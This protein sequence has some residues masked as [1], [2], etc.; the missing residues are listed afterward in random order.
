ML[1]PQGLGGTLTFPAHTNPPKNWSPALSL[2]A[3][4]LPILLSGA[5]LVAMVA[6][7][8][9]I[10]CEE[11]LFPRRPS[12]AALIQ[13]ARRGTSTARA[14]SS[15]DVCRLGVWAAAEPPGPLGLWGKAILG[16]AFCALCMNLA[17][18]D[19]TP[20]LSAA[21]LPV[22]LGTDS[23]TYPVAVTTLVALVCLGQVLLERAGLRE[24]IDYRPLAFKPRV[25]LASWGRR[26]LAFA[27]LSAPAYLTGN[28]LFAVPPLLVAF[29]ELTRPDF[30]LRARPWRAW[31]VLA[32][33]GLVGSLGRAV[34]ETAGVP[35]PLMVAVCFAALVLVWNG[36]STWLPPA[37]AV[38]LLSF[39][40]PYAGPL[41]FGV[42]VAVG[43]AAWVAVAMLFPGVRP[44]HVGRRLGARSRQPS[45]AARGQRI[46]RL[47]ASPVLPPGEG[48]CYSPTDSFRAG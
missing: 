38:V 21:I 40:V 22:L 44:G 42:E 43:A 9:A 6:A 12:C 29:T 7:S 34:V 48:E 8:Q 25:A 5:F 2:R 26:L 24:R 11:V 41:T 3:R 32:C 46:G 16:Y 31:A 36:L 27:L 33:A 23:W 39:L 19:M 4:W 1:P 37:G 35:L 10:P 17:A 28:P 20:M 45:D 15:W 30:T 18:A 14:C 47:A 13:P